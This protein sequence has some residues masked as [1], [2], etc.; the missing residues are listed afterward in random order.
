MHRYNAE[1]LAGLANRRSPGASP[2][3]T[4][5]QKAELAAL[6]EAGPD[7]QRDGVVR[8]RRIDLQARIKALFGV[9]M[10]E[11]PSVNFLASI[12]WR[13]FLGVNFLAASNWRRSAFGGCRS[14]PRHPKTDEDTQEA[15][16][17]TSRRR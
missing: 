6:V 5:E 10:H 16:K 8:W 15:F 9:A 17:K 3:L 7:L 1:G 12:S 13:Q 14:R 2:L 4:P 11:R